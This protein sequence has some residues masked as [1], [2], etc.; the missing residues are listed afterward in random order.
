MKLHKPESAQLD[1]SQ[2]EKKVEA[3]PDG[4]H[5]MSHSDSRLGYTD[6]NAVAT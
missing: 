1:K 2:S 3:D 6:F 4:M 5:A